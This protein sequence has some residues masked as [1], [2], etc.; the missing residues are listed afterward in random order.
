MESNRT[1]IVTEYKNGHYYLTITKWEDE[2]CEIEIHRCV[3]ELL[4]HSCDQKQIIEAEEIFK[5][6]EHKKPSEYKELLEN[7]TDTKV[8]R[9]D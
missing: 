4:W 7:V 1:G 9:E 3:P 5:N 2:H 8:I 6:L